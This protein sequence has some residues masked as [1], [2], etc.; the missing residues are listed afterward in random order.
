MILEIPTDAT[1]TEYEQITSLDGKPYVFGLSWSERAESWYLDVSLQRDNAEPT[2]I[3]LGMRLSIG[4]PLLVAVTTDGRP[5]GEIFPVDVS[6]GFG[7]DPGRYDLGTRVR[8]VYYDAAELGRA[9]TP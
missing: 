5:P 7:E 1:T 4:Y 3:V 2:P 8:L 6:G 9:I